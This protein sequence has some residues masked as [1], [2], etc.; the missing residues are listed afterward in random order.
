MINYES[1]KNFRAAMNHA[2]ETPITDAFKKEYG[3]LEWSGDTP[4][5]ALKTMAD[6]ER[7]LAAAEA[8]SA[9]LQKLYI[10][11]L[12]S[13]AES[14][15]A[16]Q[17]RADGVADRQAVAQLHRLVSKGFAP[18][19]DL[20]AKVCSIAQQREIDLNVMIQS[21]APA[22]PAVQLRADG[23]VGIDWSMVR[24]ILMQGA[25]IQQDYQAGK[26]ATYEHYS[27]RMD[28]AARERIDELSASPA[29]AKDWLPIESA[30]M[31]G[32]RIMVWREHND[33]DIALASWNGRVWGGYGW[34]FPL[35]GIGA[36]KYWKPE[37][38][39]PHHP[40]P[41]PGDRHE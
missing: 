5:A 4:D 30:P 8:E 32:T 26:F 28:A 19:L 20:C 41:L 15:P 29:A 36:P 9:R 34:S 6:L 11:T 27:A 13:A 39:A 12:N 22:S 35:S 1:D 16:V 23:V 7:R 33:G 24:S 38:P 10:F 17:L 18:P 25:A 21:A 2:T 14:A 3:T 40:I 31:D 37:P